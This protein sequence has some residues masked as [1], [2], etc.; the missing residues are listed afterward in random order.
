MSCAALLEVYK[1]KANWEVEL[2]NSWGGAPMLWQFLWQKY[3]QKPGVPDYMQMDQNDKV[4][5]LWNK[6]DIPLYHRVPLHFTFDRSVLLKKHLKWAAPLFRQNA[7]VLA[8]FTSRKQF[9]DHWADIAAFVEEKTFKLD[10][11]CIGLAMN[12]TSVSDLWD[13]Y[14]K[15]FSDKGVILCTS[16]D[17]V[18]AHDQ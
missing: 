9:V 17:F 13:Y 11:R 12:C 6:S 1:S 15:P 3:I 18:E 4:W 2:R 16:D 5:A 8:E 14:P 10:S 7:Q